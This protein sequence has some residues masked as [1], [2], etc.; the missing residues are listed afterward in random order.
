M[1][2][3][4]IFPEILTT[5]E[6]SE[7]FVCLIPV[8]QII[9]CSATD[10]TSQGIPSITTDVEDWTVPKPEP[11]IVIWVGVWGLAYLGVIPVTYGLMLLL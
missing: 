4:A 5:K 2:I 10:E 6:N 1:L 11:V 3:E 7:G 8:V 9:Y